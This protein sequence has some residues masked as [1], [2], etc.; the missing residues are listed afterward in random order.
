MGLLHR[1]LIFACVAYLFIATVAQAQWVWTPETGRFIRMNRL[2][3][4]TPE[5]QV[6]FARTLLLEG[7]Y[8]SA[9]LETEKFNEVYADT[10]EAAENQF[11]RG[12]IKLTQREYLDAAQEFQQVVVNYPESELYDRVIEKQYEV[13]DTLFEDGQARMERGTRKWWKLGI[14]WKPFRKRPLN[15]AVE[16]YNMVIDNQPFTE[17]AA[18]AQYK[19][20]LSH[21]AL[22]EYLEAAFEYR[23]V[24]DEYPQSGYVADA[25]YGLIETYSEGALESDYDQSPSELAVEAINEFNIRYP[26]DP[27]MNDLQEVRADMRERIAKQRFRAARFYE[28]RLAFDSARI[29]YQVVVDQFDGTS[30]AGAA[31][32]WLEAHP[33]KEAGARARVN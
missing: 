15:R 10:N 19:V 24:I 17:E 28:K 11:L 4:E 5:L 30:T 6:E 25:S 21:F 27:R 18:Q 26:A 31:Q 33:P 22:E 7:K 9:L 16:V 3:K 32:A 12:E 23:Q 2:P 8:K 20:G 13:G 1:G 29:Y 14:T